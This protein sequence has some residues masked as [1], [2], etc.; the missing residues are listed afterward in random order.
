MPP[1]TRGEAQVNSI[2]MKARQP[3]VEFDAVSAAHAQQLFIQRFNFVGKGPLEMVTAG[4]RPMT[5]ELFLLS[6]DHAQRPDRT[7]DAP[8]RI[9]LLQFP[10]AAEEPLLPAIVEIEI[11][12]DEENQ[13]I[14]R[15]GERG[16]ALFACH[17]DRCIQGRQLL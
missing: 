15:P 2:A 13:V 17:L 9:L 16:R 4:I 7:D 14:L 12:V 8:L 3:C 10:Q 11:L 1:L 6:R 5:S